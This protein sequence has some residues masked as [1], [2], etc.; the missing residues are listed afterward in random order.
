MGSVKEEGDLTRISTKAIEAH[1]SN[2]A[3][4]LSKGFT[5]LATQNKSTSSALNTHVSTLSSAIKDEAE[6]TQARVETLHSR[7]L[8]E[9]Q[10]TDTALRTSLTS[11]SSTLSHSSAKLE[12]LTPSLK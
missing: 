9:V 7:V 1:T 11:L 2:L 10:K 5:D 6:T 8:D 3:S 12:S 4:Q